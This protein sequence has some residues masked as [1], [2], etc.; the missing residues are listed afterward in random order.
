[1]GFVRRSP[2]LGLAF[3]LVLGSVAFRTLIAGQILHVVS[4]RYWE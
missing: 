1:M 2:A 4:V 3:A